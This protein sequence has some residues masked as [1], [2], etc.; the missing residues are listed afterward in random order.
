MQD[1]SSQQ[2]AA[3]LW[4]RLLCYCVWLV[5]AED[6]EKEEQQRQK[7]K[8][9][10]LEALEGIASLFLWHWRQ[11]QAGRRWRIGRRRERLYG[12]RGA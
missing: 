7:K 3:R 10:P 9:P 12:S 8:K 11:K 2:H 1:K 5:A 4:A 6:E